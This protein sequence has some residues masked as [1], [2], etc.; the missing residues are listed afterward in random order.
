M[1]R[2]LVILM[3]ALAG[4]PGVGIGLLPPD[5]VV[6][7]CG[8]TECW[9]DECLIGEGPCCDAGE[10]GDHCGLGDGLC[11]CGVMPA[12]RHD[13][14]SD[15]PLTRPERGPT[16]AF[17]IF[18]DASGERLIFTGSASLGAT[19]DKLARRSGLTRSG[20]RAMLGCWLS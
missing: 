5:S 14:R 10:S 11:R 12:P 6:V 8:A 4:I 3:L 19:P 13:P 7:S 9:G 17:A 15:T 16:S 20:A 2:T 18:L 1:M